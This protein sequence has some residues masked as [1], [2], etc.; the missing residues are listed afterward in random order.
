MKANTNIP[1]EIRNQIIS[2]I[3]PF[4]LYM[5]TKDDFKNQSISDTC[6]ILLRFLATS[7]F[8]ALLLLLF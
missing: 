3:T 7:P 4:M 5:Y 2:D 6:Y 1:F 8:V